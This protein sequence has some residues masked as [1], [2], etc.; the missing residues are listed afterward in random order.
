MSDCPFSPRELEAVKYL[1]D[2]LIAKTI[3]F[4]MGITEPGV[5]NLL[6]IAR[7][8]AGKHTATGL[9]A[10]AIREGWIS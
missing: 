6:K 2:G 8:K 5:N 9:V 10:H 3:A 1:A 4:K 7:L